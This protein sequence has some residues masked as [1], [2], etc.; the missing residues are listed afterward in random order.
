MTPIVPTSD[1]RS[2]GGG[3]RTAG[4]GVRG[5]GAAAGGCLQQFPGPRVPPYRLAA[6]RGAAGPALR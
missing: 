5:E 3:E 4:G 6:G 1:W 2:A